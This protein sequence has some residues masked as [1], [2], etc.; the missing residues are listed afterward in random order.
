MSRVGKLPVEIPSGVTITVDGSTI[1]AVG[2]KGTLETAKLPEV[3]VAV[4]DSN[5]IVTR[6]SDEKLSRSQHGLMRSLINNMVIGVTNG[7]EKKLEASGVGF[8]IALQGNKLVLNLGF[9]HPIEYIAPEGITLAVDKMNI[10]VS[11]ADKQ[12]VGQVAADIRAFKKPEPYKG[13][14]IKY[15]D[16]YIIRKAGKT[17]AK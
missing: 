16:E 15:S 13:K 1:K 17:G 8:K 12:Q 6:K 9:S 14:G 4:E 11:G 7:F 10:T 2:P 3:D 5:V